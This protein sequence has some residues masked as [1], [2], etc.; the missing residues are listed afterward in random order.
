MDHTLDYWYKDL[1]GL[2]AGQIAKEHINQP[3]FS[4][5]LVD[6][7]VGADHGQ[8]FFHAGVKNVF[9]NLDG[10]IKVMVIYG[11]GES[12]CQKATAKLLA[13]AFTPRLNTAFK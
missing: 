10:S 13:L 6:F 11:L 8:G 12:E 7:V 1:D 2:L 9:R 5:A 4:Y 3:A